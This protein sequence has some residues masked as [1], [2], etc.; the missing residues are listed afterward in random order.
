MHHFAL[1]NIQ[2]MKVCINFCPHRGLPSL[3][4]S[5]IR[6][7][8]YKDHDKRGDKLVLFDSKTDVREDSDEQVSGI[9][10]QSFTC[11]VAT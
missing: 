5:Q 6:L 4:R 9:S 1:F 7:L 2:I 11:S 8:V 3:E 10:L